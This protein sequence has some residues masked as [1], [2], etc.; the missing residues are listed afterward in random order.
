MQGLRLVRV[1]IN[2]AQMD[3]SKKSLKV[4]TSLIVRVDFQQ[5]TRSAR[6][7]VLSKAAFQLAR[8]LTTNGTALGANV[9]AAVGPERMLI[10]IAD[11]LAAAIKPLV[12]WKQSKGIQ[13]DVVR[14]HGCRTAQKKA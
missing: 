4:T 13:T 1:A 2:P 14:P 8:T 11:N 12:A 5:K 9:V 6:P 3:L 10:I 7:I